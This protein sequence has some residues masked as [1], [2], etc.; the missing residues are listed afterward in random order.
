MY[1]TNEKENDQFVKMFIT[2]DA[3]IW[4]M[5]TL[6]PNIGVL[7]SEASFAYTGIVWWRVSSQ[8]RTAQREL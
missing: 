5:G 2:I 6:R 4:A 8:Q 3:P 1:C 7:T